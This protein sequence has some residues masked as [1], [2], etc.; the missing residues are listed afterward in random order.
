MNFAHSTAHEDGDIMDRK[1]VA[2]A[3]ALLVFGIAFVGWLTLNPPPPKPPGNTTASPPPA[4]G[5]HQFGLYIGTDPH[6]ADNVQ[7]A[8]DPG[9][10]YAKAAG[11]DTVISYD[12]FHATPSGVQHYLDAAYKLG[13]HVVLNMQD[14]GKVKDPDVQSFYDTMYG[15]T[16]TAWAT[17]ILQTYAPHPAVTS[18]NITDEYPEDPDTTG[19]WRGDLRARQTLI[20]QYTNKPIMLTMLWPNLPEQQRRAFFAEV[21]QAGDEL[22]IDHYPIPENSKYGTLHNID[23]AGQDLR[24]VNP[25]KG[26]FVA[27]AFGWSSPNNRQTGVSLG[28]PADA[29]PPTVAQMTDMASRAL[30]NGA[31]NVMFY[32]L[33]DL[34]AAQQDALKVAMQQLRSRFVCPGK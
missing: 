16:P 8:T 28:F 21:L 13:L 25:G 34:D 27:Q 1:L 2:L 4:C 18:I 20:R 11:F 22:A 19:D 14:W 5:P 30:N 15:P 9:L 29:S 17:K 32:S 7:S 24:T 3:L 33:P 6:M 10:L 12:M 31:Q 23:L 26:W